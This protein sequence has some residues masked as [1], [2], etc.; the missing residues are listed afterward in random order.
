[1]SYHIY[2]IDKN[3]KS[4]HTKYWRECESVETLITINR[5]VNLLNQLG[6]C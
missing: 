3:M 6:K 4:D 5:T 1:M 2:Q